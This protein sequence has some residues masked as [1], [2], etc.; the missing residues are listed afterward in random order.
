MNLCG[1]GSL[2]DWPAAPVSLPSWR[3]ITYPFSLSL[4]I[5]FSWKSKH[6]FISPFFNCKYVCFFIT[7]PTSKYLTI[8]YFHTINVFIILGHKYN[9]Q[10]LIRYYKFHALLAVLLMQQPEAASSMTLAMTSVASRHTHL[11]ARTGALP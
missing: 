11:P 9:Y 7:I 4:V 3:F 10:S 1:S 2:A 6:H 8:S 5:N